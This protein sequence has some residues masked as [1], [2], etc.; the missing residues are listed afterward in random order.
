MRS[1]GAAVLMLCL[2]VCSAGI[3]VAQS[4]AAEGVVRIGTYDNRAIAIAYAHSQ[5]LPLVEKT[6]EYD[7]AEAAGDTVRMEE[8]NEYMKA[9]QRQ[10]HR[11]GFGRAPVDDL[12]EPVAD[13]MPGL[14]ADLGV[15]AIVWICDFAGQGV[16]VIDVTMDLVGL[17]DPTQETIDMCR[18]VFEYEPV[19]LDELDDAD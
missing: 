3:F 8:I 6:R 13:R 16:E 2:A 14:A 5:Y 7:S 11:Q 17:Y 15:D 18:K 1:R 9:L 19:D 10:L 12:L 4:R